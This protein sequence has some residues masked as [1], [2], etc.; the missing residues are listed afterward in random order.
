MADPGWQIDSWT[1]TSNNSSTASTN[2]LTMPASAHSASVIYEEIPPSTG[3]TAYNDSSW[4]TGQTTTN[5]TTFSYDTNTSGLLKNYAT[6]ANTTV[7]AQITYN[8]SISKHPT[9]GTETAVGTDAYNTFH[10]IAD[11]VGVVNFIVPPQRDGG[12]M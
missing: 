2:T 5:I 3:W 1:G 9:T 7:T 11:I 4:A 12:P 10:G 6:G 8:G